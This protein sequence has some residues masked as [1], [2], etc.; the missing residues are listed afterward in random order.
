MIQL[1][2]AFLFL[3]VTQSAY[4]IDSAVDQ[5]FWCG[6]SI[7]V[8]SDD[9]VVEQKNEA[10]QHRKILFVHSNKGIAYRSVDYGQKWENVTQQ[11]ID[12]QKLDSN[13]KFKD[14][15]QSPADSFTMYFI[16]YNQSFISQD[17]GRTYRTFNDNRLYGFRFNKLNKDQILAFQEKKCN[18]TDK[19]CKEQ[20]KR[21][22]W[23]TN[24]GGQIWQPVL[25]HVRDAAWDKL[26]HYE[27]VPD[28]RIIVSHVD[29]QGELKVSYSDDFFKT[30]KQIEKDCFGFYQTPTYLFLLVRPDQ[31]SVGYD[32]KMSPHLGETYFPQEIVLPID[33][34]SKHTFTVLDV[35]DSIVY[36]SV[37]HAE[38]LSKVTNIYMSDG[39]EFTVSLLGNVRS[40]DTG[41]CDFEKIKSMKGVYIAN[42]FDYDE[43]EKTKSRRKRINSERE[44]KLQSSDRLDQ[45]KKSVITF[46]LGAEW[47][48]LKA[49]KYSYA[50]QPLN[51]NGDC[52][53][54]LKGRT[55]TTSLIYS[56]EQAVGIIIGTGNTGL[57]L[58][59]QETNTYLSRDGGHNW[60]EILNGTYI[61]EIGDH[62]GLI[63]FAESE[64]YTNVAKF[65]QDEGMTFQDIK[66]NISL[67]IDNIVTE[68][69]NEEQKFLIY[70]RIK[71]SDNPQEDFWNKY[72]S[73][74]G[75]LI[76][77]DLSNVYQRVCKGSENPEDPD[78][79]YEYW[80]PQNYQQQK[81]LFGQKV[82]YQRK[83][84]EAKCKNPEIVK[85]L[86]V[87]NCPCT[88]EDWECDLGFMR[89]IDGGEC[90]PMTYGFSSQPPPIKCTG[91]YMKSQGYR[92]IPGDEC[93][94][95]V[96]LGP[97]EQECPTEK[98]N[99]QV[100]QIITD[101]PIV[102]NDQ[103]KQDNLDSQS[104]NYQSQTGLQSKPFNILDY[105][106]YIILSIM[107]VTL[108][109]LRNL[110][111]GVV[112]Q[113]FS[114][115]QVN[116]N[117]KKRSYY[118]PSEEELQEKKQTSKKRL[119]GIQST[120]DEDEEAGL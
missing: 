107:I 115:S 93:E 117:R 59:G 15:I 118:P 99:I 43:I 4:I 110:I 14:I 73:I 60:Y 67:D 9:D 85:K 20:Y 47:H 104:P 109:Y 53:L 61:Y 100:N 82:K 42:I 37:A 64:S 83:K 1:Y 52:S 112:K 44:M 87:E 26:I 55:E 51:C 116:K 8:T 17:C 68:P 40:Q 78:S 50:G 18:K 74:I 111:W 103:K 101:K 76:P 66:L 19:S 16:G 84:R 2:L 63:V 106:E 48:S 79:D 56:S 41:H 27:M 32:L 22:L 54:H 89:K 12:Q 75:V 11:L 72:E 94:G 30:I 25:D 38:E 29:N 120:K 108:L 24:N 71:Q 39:N 46:D 6:G 92:K 105:A 49:P 113:I 90:V 86:L 23:V 88:A 62:G 13:Y 45:Y 96:Y 97:I 10:K 34:Q 36:M 81:C 5:V 70:G 114:A 58:D 91:T 31:Y 102:K 28:M 98:T 77:I 33:D 3:G 95:G 21:E 35:T 7:I 65:T 119:F 69:S 80:S 57:Y